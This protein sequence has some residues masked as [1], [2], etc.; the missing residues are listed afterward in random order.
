[1]EKEQAS[2]LLIDLDSLFDT[3][4]GICIKHFYDTLVEIFPTD[5]YHHRLDN[6]FNGTIDQEAFDEAYGKRDKTVLVDSTL[7]GMVSIIKDFVLSISTKDS[8]GPF[9]YYPKVIINTYPYIL[10]DEE[11]QN[12]K[13]GLSGHLRDLVPIELVHM[14]PEELTVSFIKENITVL[15]LYHYNKWLDTQ[16]TLGNFDKT[17]IPDVTLFGPRIFFKEKPKTQKEA[18]D[19]FM[20]L[21]NIARPYVN[22]ELLPSM[23]F[24]TFLRAEEKTEETSE[25]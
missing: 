19:A 14:S 22:L 5:K 17:A 2:C 12:I 10:E 25:A 9:V 3:R 23:F 8:S 1:M 15:I 16:T 18:D 6:S 24:S 21:T 4:L 7:S 20:L 13:Q 11:K